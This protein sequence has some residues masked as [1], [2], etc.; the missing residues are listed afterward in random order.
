VRVY[1]LGFVV[2]TVFSILLSVTWMQGSAGAVWLVAMRIGQGLGGAMLMANAVALVTD[3]FPANQR[4]L[5]L[6]MQQIAGVAGSTAGLV[7][8]GLLAPVSWRLIFLVSVPVGVFGTVW[9]FLKLRDHGERRVARVD[10]W[11][12][13]TFAVGLILLMVAITSGIQ[14]YGHHAM[15]WTSPL[16]EGEIAAGLLLLAL[17]AVIESRVAEPM[18]ELALFRIRAFTA[19]NVAAFLMSLA[20][21]GLQFIL[22]IWLQGI[23]L[24]EHGYSFAS[25]P[26]W[27]GI[28][29]LPLIA[30]LLIAGPTAG[31]LSDRF[32]AR[33]FATAGPLLAALSF[34]LLAHLPVDFP[35][36][37]FAF[38]LLLSGISGGLFVSPNRA[39]VMNSLPPWRRGVGAGMAST[40]V[41]SA[42]VLS[43][44]VFFSLM[45]VGLSA[46]LPSTLFH[47]LVAR[48]VPV[49]AASHLASLPPA[50]TLFATFLGYNP[51]AHLL[52]VHVLATLPHNQVTVL[53]GH[54]FFPL[55]MTEPFAGALNAAFTFAIVACLLAAGASTMR[56]GNYRWSEAP[57]SEAAG[58]PG[59]DA[60]ALAV[61]PASRTVA[62]TT[63]P[64]PPGALE[65]GPTEGA[66]R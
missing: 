61:M 22:I 33:P 2:F 24:P 12:N 29:M 3:A 20:S 18:F 36:P 35:Y 55:L 58:A 56:G 6:G 48:D 30:G 28:Y 16:V 27:A 5:A 64:A 41:F 37:V 39:A 65:I 7:L 4:G 23:W 15:S 38:L 21:G 60:A 32:G 9:A 47:G 57:T 40:A 45:I 63:Q 34:L 26:L 66:T 51:I 52:G 13:A 17:F 49:R 11:G 54:R 31:F 62:V 10:W 46:H 43:I 59:D 1:N 44:G 50:S 42:Q 8:G 25:T 19:G 14:P 53:T